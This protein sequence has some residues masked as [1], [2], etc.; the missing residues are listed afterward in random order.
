MKEA[1]E[2]YLKYYS[3]IHRDGPA[4]G[5]EVM[6]GLTRDEL[7]VFSRVVGDIDVSELGPEHIARYA[8]AIDEQGTDKL[9]LY[10]DR[11]V[12]FEQLRDFC[13][14]LVSAGMLKSNPVSSRLCGPWWYRI[15]ALRFKLTLFSLY[16][17]VRILKLVG[18]FVVL[19]SLLTLLGWVL[20]G[21]HLNKVPA[22]LILSAYAAS[23]L[24]IA[25]V[26]FGMFYVTRQ[27]WRKR[28]GRALKHRRPRLEN[29]K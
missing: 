2:S 3:A 15:R 11:Q 25:I 5:L 24:L 8:S 27:Y 26:V 4:E 17:G 28:T 23:Y 14:W 13:S 16:A 22:W 21:N 18:T 9:K 20:E 19:F 6:V 12:I 10:R 29:H 1:I 7:T